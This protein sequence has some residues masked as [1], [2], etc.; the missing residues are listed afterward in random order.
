MVAKGYGK[1]FSAAAIA[2]GSLALGRAIGAQAFVVPLVLLGAGSW[3]LALR[4]AGLRHAAV[5]MLM[6]FGLATFVAYWLHAT[7][8][9]LVQLHRALR[10]LLHAGDYDGEIVVEFAD[11]F[12][13]SRLE[14]SADL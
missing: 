2:V 10:E 12:P 5:L 7:R 13:K 4:G 14:C 6:I 3:L 11:R 8:V 9:E 1:G